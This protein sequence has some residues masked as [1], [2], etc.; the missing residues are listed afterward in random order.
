MLWHP[1]V[2]TSKPALLPQRNL[3]LFCR[4]SILVTLL[5]VCTSA[6]DLR[7]VG[8]HKNCES[9]RRSE[10]ADILLKSNDSELDGMG[11]P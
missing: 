7:V 2:E 6:H 11:L 10:E 9:R 3:N 1:W 5:L 8:K 4:L